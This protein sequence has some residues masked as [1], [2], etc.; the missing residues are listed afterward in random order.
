MRH[1]I[2]ALLAVLGLPPTTLAQ[3]PCDGRG[4][5]PRDARVDA[6]PPLGCT[7]APRAPGFHLFTPAHRAVTR[8]IGFRL[9]EARALDCVI[10]RYAC[11]GLWLVPVVAREVRTYGYVLDV[12]EQACAVVTSATPALR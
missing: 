5:E 12:A 11:T 8:R 4:S 9:G 6:G 1:V 2:A 10:V 7:F 3:S